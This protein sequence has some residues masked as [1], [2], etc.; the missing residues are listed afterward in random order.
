MQTL[1]LAQ[2]ASEAPSLQGVFIT[3]MPDCLLFDS[4]TRT[5]QPWELEEVA[6]YFGDL[7]RANT[8]ALKSLGNWSSDAQVTVETEESLIVLRELQNDFVVS[9]VFERGTPIGMLRIQ[10]KRM[11]T[12]IQQALAAYQPEEVPR[13]VRVL[14][15]LQRYA[16]DPHTSMTR[17]AL[18]AGVPLDALQQP[19]QLTDGQI[20]QIEFA[21]QDILG[22]QELRL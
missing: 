7:T 16:P 12:Q 11:L 4:F 18:I 5:N 13:V 10:V 9:F 6:S 19:Q 21:V 2:T 8:R 22:L 17:V 14:D 15:Y 1:N 20:Q 3:A